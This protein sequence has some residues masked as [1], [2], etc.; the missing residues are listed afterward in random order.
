MQFNQI[1]AFPIVI[2]RGA[3][4]PRL[5]QKRIRIVIYTIEV[6]VEVKEPKNAK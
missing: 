4:E 2:R 5:G 1:R 6:V 3:A